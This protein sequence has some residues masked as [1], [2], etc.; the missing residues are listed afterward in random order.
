MTKSR[1]Q[2]L[3]ALA[4]PDQRSNESSAGGRLFRKLAL[5]WRPAYQS[6]VLRFLVAGGLSYV[7][8][9]AFLYAFVEHIFIGITGDLLRFL[10]ARLLLS[11]LAALEISI[12]VRF[13]LNDRWTFRGRYERPFLVRL[14]QSNLG[15]F[16]GPLITLATVNML[17]PLMGISYLLTNSLGILL[18]LVWNWLWSNHVVWSRQDSVERR[19]EEVQ[20]WRQS[21]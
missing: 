4:Q 21:T 20:L 9:Q 10:S 8:N 15:A 1:T 7:V 12:L 16:G 5:H 6:T 3:V 19:G 18:G 17:T 13:Y 2:D 14:Y 11:S